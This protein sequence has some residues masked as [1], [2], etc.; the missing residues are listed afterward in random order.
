MPHPLSSDLHRRL[1]AYVESGHSRHEAAARFQTSVSCVVKLMQRWNQTGSI[2]PKPRGGFR[3]GKIGPHK[4]FILAAVAARRDITMQ[5]L[6]QK[7]EAAKSIKVHP[8]TLSK[9]L[10]DCG[11]SVKK[12]PSGQ[13]TRQA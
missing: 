1:V 6:A 3:H 10:I 11:L 5:E 2:K 13:R 9:F 8:A 12:N 4:D 7:L